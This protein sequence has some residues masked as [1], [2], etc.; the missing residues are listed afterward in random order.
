[1]MV[2]KKLLEETILKS[3]QK[4]HD[5]P[6]LGYRGD[7]GTNQDIYWAQLT[8]RKGDVIGQASVDNNKQKANIALLLRPSPLRITYFPNRR[9]IT[10][11]DQIQEPDYK[12]TGHI[13][14]QDWKE[15]NKEVMITKKNYESQI[16]TLYEFVSGNTN[17]LDF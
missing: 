6:H 14:K 7:F 10:T 13:G 3:F 11:H 12:T 16:N 9:I 5:I 8:N 17:H 2:M 1:M 15:P 4:E